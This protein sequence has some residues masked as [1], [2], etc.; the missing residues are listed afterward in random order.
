[1]TNCSSNNNN[2]LINH[3]NFDH[4]AEQRVDV[5]MIQDRLY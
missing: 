3:I 4:S 1:M 2:K 5:A